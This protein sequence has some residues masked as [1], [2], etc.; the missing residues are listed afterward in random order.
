MADD[1]QTTIQLST[2]SGLV[3]FYATK[4]GSGNYT[5]QSTPRVTVARKVDD[6]NPMPVQSPPLPTVSSSALEN[7]HV[8]KL[9]PG[10]LFTLRVNAIL[11]GYVMLFDA[12]S[13]PVDGAVAPRATW[14]FDSQTMATIDKTFNAP[15]AARCTWAPSS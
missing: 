13:V 10:T 2:S 11:T 4:D 1:A 5:L 14:F 12:N 9:T 3:S 8:L 15:L 7:S 6:S